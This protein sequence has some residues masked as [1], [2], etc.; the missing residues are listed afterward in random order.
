MNLEA[1]FTDA[2]TQLDK[3]GDLADPGVL[4]RLQRARDMF[5]GTNSLD[6]FRSCRTPEDRFVPIPGAKADED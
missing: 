1:F 2:R 3:Q 4:E 6:H 5:G